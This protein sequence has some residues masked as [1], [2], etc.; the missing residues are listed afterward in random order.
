MFTK[1]LAVQANRHFTGDQLRRHRSIRATQLAVAQGLR[2]EKGADAHFK[3]ITTRGMGG[4]L[5]FPPAITEST[6]TAHWIRN[7]HTMRQKTPDV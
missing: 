6:A 1:N 5:R 2:A 3:K 4:R 7:V